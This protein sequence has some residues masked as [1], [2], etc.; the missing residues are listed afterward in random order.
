MT[1]STMTPYPDALWLN[2]SPVLKSLHSPLLRYLR[3]SYSLGEWD[4]SQS[5]DEPSCLEI[6]LV[7]LHDYLKSC[8]RP[9]HLIGHS[10]GGL[11]GW[12]YAQRYPKR[13]RS[14]TLLAVGAF[15]AVDWQAHYYA[16]R[17]VL[18]IDREHLLL[19]M[20]KLLFSEQPCRNKLKRLIQILD[21]DLTES[22]SPHSLIN[23][24]HLPAV[25]QL[26]IPLSIFGGEQDLVVDPTHIDRWQPHLKPGDQL[27][28]CPQG[29][30]FFHTAFPSVV[31]DRILGFCY[32][33][34]VHPL[35]CHY[36]ALVES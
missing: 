36:S 35:T 11:L 10:T 13:V 14:L 6:A 32:K 4:Y 24:T 5:S 21:R 25:Q 16:M 30:H 22:L 27:W 23:M 34:S 20:A 31:G 29:R 2:P 1:L 9:M 17:Q 26:P 19:H 12:L 8:D 28:L 15:P 33:I 7:L 3:Q 18:P